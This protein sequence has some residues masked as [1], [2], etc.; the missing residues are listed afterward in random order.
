MKKNKFKRV[1]T[2]VSLIA[3][4]MSQLSG[5]GLFPK[6]EEALAPPLVPPKKQE[7]KQYKVVKKPIEKK[8]TSS[9]TLVSES[10]SS[11]YFK[12]SPKRIKHINVKVGDLVKKGDLLVDTE[13][14]NIDTQIK[15]QEYN[16]KMDEID[17]TELTTKAGISAGDIEK[18]RLRLLID[19]T[20]LADLKS[21][22]Q[23]A[24]L[25]SPIGGQ[26][27]FVENLKDGETVDTYKIIVTVGDQK[28]LM[29]YS[30]GKDM[31]SIKLGMKAKV[32]VNDQSLEGTVIATPSS[33][34]LTK[35]E[36]LKKGI[37]I[38]LNN[39]PTGSKIGDN[40]N[41]EIA[42]ETKTSALVIP[43]EG[44]RTFSNSST[45]EVWDGTSKKELQVQTG[46]K[47]ATEVEIIS[48]LNEGQQII[49][50]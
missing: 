8:F 6:E 12:D 28:K 42:L 20:K 18:S 4:I 7:Y 46:I 40:A 10:Q 43:I 39:V 27:V 21:Q 48:G 14:G 49:L 31:E 25:T 11:V 33:S 44:L 5:C 9:G 35:D 17:Y 16:V 34:Q 13:V 19:Q 24:R 45:V 2:T 26:V 15:I 23:S 29:V 32:T 22:Q 50:N 36:T 30:E 1:I 38:K 41:I 3:L 37:N 47:T